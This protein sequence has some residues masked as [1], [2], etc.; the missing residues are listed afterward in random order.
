MTNNEEIKRI[1]LEYASKM[2]QLNPGHHLSDVIQGLIENSIDSHCTQ[3]SIFLENDGLSSIKII[4]DGCGIPKSSFPNICRF[5][6]TSKIQELTQTEIFHGKSF[7]FT[8]SFL[9][10]L[11]C[12]STVKVSSRYK[13]EIQTNTGVFQFNVM[14]KCET[15]YEVDIGTR[16]EVINY[17]YCYP[18]QRLKIRKNEKEINK[19][20]DTVAKYST[21]YSWI[22]FK[23]VL[24]ER[25]TLLETFGNSDILSNIAQIHSLAEP[26]K[27]FHVASFENLGNDIEAIIFISNPRYNFVTSTTKFLRGFF[28]NGRLISAPFLK[29]PINNFYKEFKRKMNNCYV[30]MPY[31]VFIKAPETYFS[32]FFNENENEFP[33]FI[34][35]NQDDEENKDF[36]REEK[37]FFQKFRSFDAEKLTQEIYQIITYSK[38]PIINIYTITEIRKIEAKLINEFL[39]NPPVINDTSKCLYPLPT[40]P[41]L[42]ATS[43]Q[44]PQLL[45]TSINNKGNKPNL[46]IPVQTSIS[47][48]NVLSNQHQQT[49]HPNQNQAQS[50]I[51]PQSQ[52][53][54]Q[55]QS[56]TIQTPKHTVHTPKS[57]IVKRAISPAPQTILST[58]TSA[59]SLSNHQNQSSAN[60]AVS[61]LLLNTTT[62]N[63]ESQQ[64]HSSSQNPPDSPSIARS[65][66]SNSSQKLPPRV[67]DISELLTNSQNVP[68]VAKKVLVRKITATQ[69]SSTSNASSNSQNSTGNSSN[70]N[71]TNSQNTVSVNRPPTTAAV[72]RKK[73]LLPPKVSST[74]NTSTTTTNTNT[75]GTANNDNN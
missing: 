73:I 4:D 53:N 28:L 17:L 44:P 45:Q 74:S 25:V 72:V 43:Q 52:Q 1:P 27:L 7:G 67:T 39:C 5:H 15:S 41:A 55:I 47:V 42:L 70:S 66:S 54:H 50:R 14:T 31:Y 26:L 9:A 13:R 19:M 11:S 12:V 38:T 35:T 69:L 60:S 40:N 65:N 68:T 18:N 10:N 2:K 59:P 29:K 64:K 37:F 46:G 8:G 3:I 34:D 51:I 30:K 61:N 58:T 75:T 24:N 62:S 20:I 23:L 21:V 6:W 56:K 36:L 33:N 16:V 63:S 49:Q 32:D 57:P 48:T 22:K 71:T